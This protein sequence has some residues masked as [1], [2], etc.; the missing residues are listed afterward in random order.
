LLVLEGVLAII[1]VKTWLVLHKEVLEEVLR[2]LEEPGGWMEEMVVQ[3][4]PKVPEEPEEPLRQPDLLEL[5]TP[6]E[7]EEMVCTPM[8]VLEELGTTEAEVEV[9]LVILPKEKEA[10]VVVDH[11][12]LLEQPY[13]QAL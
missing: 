4:V 12:T 5:S 2:E 3:L 8:V 10:E 11:H 7:P 13:P 9:D 1:A 6:E